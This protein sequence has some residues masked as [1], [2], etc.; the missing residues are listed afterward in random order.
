[1][2]FQATFGLVKITSELTF[3]LNLARRVQAGKLNFFSSCNKTI[4]I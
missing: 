4:N 3:W 1:M 2:G